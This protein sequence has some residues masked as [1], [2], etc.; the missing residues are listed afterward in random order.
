MGASGNII[1]LASDLGNQLW[2]SDGTASGTVGIEF[3]GQPL[4][5][6][7]AM[8][9]Q[10]GYLHYAD[11][12]VFYGNNLSTGSEMFYS[13]GT[14][15]GSRLL[16]DLGQGSAGAPQL[17]I[18]DIVSDTLFFRANFNPDY[19]SELY[20]LSLNPCGGITCPEGYTCVGG[21]C[22]PAV[23]SCDGITCPEGQVCVMG[24]CFDVVDENG[25]QVL[26][27]S[28]FGEP[29]SG[30]Q[31]SDNVY[32]EGVT[33][34]LIDEAETK[35]MGQTTTDAEGKF[36]FEN[37]PAGTFKVFVNYP[38]YQIDGDGLI[39][40]KPNVKY[41]NLD[42]ILVDDFY[43][44]RLAYVTGLAEEFLQK[45]TFK[46]YPNPSHGKVVLS[47]KENIGNVD[48]RIRDIT[49]RLIYQKYLRIYKG[50]D[51]FIADLDKESAGLKIF[52]FY[53]KGQLIHESIIILE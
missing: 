30:G 46:L 20:A 27:G 50:E 35:V 32:I 29:A 51:I 53:Q 19:G 9:F 37:L 41:A 17:H 22:F 26:S 11:G 1:F 49:G 44:L 23:D 21:T 28:L 40:L 16:A 34:Y 14:T 45:E 33:I 6:K 18:Y 47:S 31:T 3:D 36:L 5:F 13:D 25:N 52:E 48:V 38:P 8:G 7:N 43:E 24:A 4:W 12:I 15:A 10:K 2:T 39:L 42:I